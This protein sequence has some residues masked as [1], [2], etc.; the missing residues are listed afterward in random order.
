MVRVFHA[1]SLCTAKIQFCHVSL[2]NE[3]IDR[4]EKTPI[5]AATLHRVNG[6]VTEKVFA[7]PV[8][9]VIV[10]NV[11]KTKNKS[12]SFCPKNRSCIPICNVGLRHEPTILPKTNTESSYESLLQK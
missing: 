1:L 3:D 11:P 6:N 10:K 12:K 4:L 5:G 7:G 2:V 8:T 9:P